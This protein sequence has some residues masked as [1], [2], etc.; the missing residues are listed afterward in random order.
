MSPGN[1]L[2][3]VE[4]RG[5]NWSADQHGYLGMSYDPAYFG[6]AQSQLVTGFAQ[7]TRIA[8]PRPVLIGHVV[9]YVQVAGSGLTASQCFA[10][11]YDSAGNLVGLSG[12]LSGVLNSTGLKSIAVTAQGGRSLV[13]GGP[14]PFV[15]V[16]FLTNGT[17]APTLWGQ[18]NAANAT[19]LNANLVDQTRR[20]AYTGGALTALPAPW[21]GGET[22]DG[23]VFWIA[24]AT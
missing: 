4:P 13:Q 17:T 23:R 12:D 14:N 24:L 21:P 1:F 18:I 15:R 11:V 6:A 3:G 10:G 8:L 20:A 5:D 22:S 19:I 2:A 16:A 7:T 9:T